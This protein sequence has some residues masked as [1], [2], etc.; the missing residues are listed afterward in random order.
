M[1]DN[2]TMDTLKSLLG[3]DAEQKIQTV[4][5]SLSGSDSGNENKVAEQEQSETGLQNIS[6]D[7]ASLDSILK[8]KGIIDELGSQNSDYRSNLLLSLKPFMRGKRQQS[9]DS[10]IKLLNL[11]KLATLFKL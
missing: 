3:N 9:I 8:I 7:S 4:L 1:P 2:S 5:S 10:A 11:S 6:P